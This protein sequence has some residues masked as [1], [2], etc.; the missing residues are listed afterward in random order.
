MIL[1]VVTCCGVWDGVKCELWK[2]DDICCE[3]MCGLMLCKV[4]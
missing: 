1:P 3:V 4:V 2:E